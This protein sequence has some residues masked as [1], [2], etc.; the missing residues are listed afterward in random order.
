[1]AEPSQLSQLIE[2]FVD[3]SRSPTQQVHALVPFAYQ[4]SLLNYSL[5]LLISLI[6]YKCQEKYWNLN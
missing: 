3:S 2:S 4:L 6:V 1:M 5:L